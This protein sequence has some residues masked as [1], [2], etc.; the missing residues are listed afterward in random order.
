MLAE[1]LANVAPPVPLPVPAAPT[2]SFRAARRPR[3]TGRPG[4]PV[5]G[6]RPGARPPAGGSYRRPRRPALLG[7]DGHHRRGDRARPGG[8]RAWPAGRF[9]HRSS[10]S[11][12]APP[13][14]GPPSSSVAV[15][16]GLR[17]THAGQR[18]Q[19][20]CPG[21]RRRKRGRRP[22]DER[23]RQQPGHVLAHRLLPHL[24]RTGQPE[25]GH[26]A[27]TGYGQASPAEPGGGP[28]RRQLLRSRPDRDRERQRP[29]A[30]RAEQLHLRGEQHHRDTASRPST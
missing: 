3:A 16:S 27:H 10:P 24:S 20:R 6:R 9:S 12:S 23:D 25:E 22:G 7:D 14:G 29:G 17:R 5:P 11:A 30:V 8:G 2:T 18:E 26:R 4:P 13:T 1:A 19:L 21:R 15:R 28:V